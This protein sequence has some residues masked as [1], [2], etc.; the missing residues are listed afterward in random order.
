VLGVE[1]AA[2]LVGRPHRGIGDP[3][4]VE[5]AAAHARIL[6]SNAA[7]RR[8][9]RGTMRCVPVELVVVRR[10]RS[11]L[12]L[13]AALTAIVALLAGCGSSTGSAS[14]GGGSSVAGT[15]LAPAA[16]TTDLP[17]MTVAQLPP[18]GRDTLVLIAAGGPFPYSKDG[19]TFQNREGLLPKQ[20]SGFYQEYTVETPGSSDRGARRIITGKDGARFYTDDHY[21]SFRE[22]VSGGGS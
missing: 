13:L 8:A 1:L 22:V 20:K 4:T 12:A 14:P 6:S 17:T 11:A 19:V 18:E 7:T 15:G 5:V 21:D 3:G 16:A 10:S 9:G 2:A